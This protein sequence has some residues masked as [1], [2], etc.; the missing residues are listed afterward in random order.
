MERINPLVEPDQMWRIKAACRGMNV[1]V[2][3]PERG[4]FIAVNKAK[5]ICATCPVSQAC[6]ED[7]LQVNDDEGIRGGLSARQRRDMKSANR[8]PIRC[9]GCH[10]MFQP[11]RWDN[12]TCSKVC[13]KNVHNQQ[14][15]ESHARRS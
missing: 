10:Q 15:R 8:L 9:A 12:R 13:L 5:A 4:D 7:V 11:S 6:L 1:D 14:K 2:F 3:Y